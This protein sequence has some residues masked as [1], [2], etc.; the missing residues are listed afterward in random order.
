M[1]EEMKAKQMPSSHKGQK[2]IIKF[3]TFKNK[4]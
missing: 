3:I 1:S 4:K 2:K